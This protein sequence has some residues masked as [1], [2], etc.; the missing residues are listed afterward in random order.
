LQRSTHADAINSLT[1]AIDLLQKL[2]DSPERIQRELL[3]QLALGPALIAVKAWAAPEVERAYTRARELCERLGDPPEL[4]PVLWG[5]WVMHMV[6]G[7][8]RTAHELAEQLLRQAQSAH[9][10]ALL[11]LGHNAL[12]DTLFYMGELLLAREH[13]EL[14]ISLYD[15]ERHWPLTFR[16]G[17]VDPCVVCLSYACQTL[18]TL[19]Y[20][21][22][23]LK[24]GNE[25]VALAQALSH[26]HSLI[27]AENF[28]GNLRQFRREA[29]AAQEA[30]ERLIALSTE[31]GI[32]DFLAV[33]TMQRG[34]AMA[35]QG[36]TEGE[37]AQIQEGLAA[38]RATGAEVTLPYYLSWL[39][40]AYGE[41]GRLDNEL[42]ALTQALAAADE[43]EDRFWIAEIHRLKGELLLKQNHSNVAEAQSCFRRAVEIA[44]NQSAKSL[45][46]RATTS[47]ARLLAKQGRRDEA[48][49]MLGEIYGW[50][51]E[52]FDTADLKDA[53]AL[54]DELA[55]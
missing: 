45:V 49:T 53:K 13:L 34:W 18:W 48:R 42:G 54:L 21:D 27:F 23:A 46:L 9:D 16:Y 29:R 55:E 38:Q 32:N 39:A 7:E 8:L 26:P 6:R 5:L 4:F 40:E 17:G 33:A 19:G 31:R 41:T 1:A 37:I 25:A 30:A 15:R 28:L 50:F 11:L 2:P 14:A 43:N 47:L 20:P 24:R 10:Q 52:G 44:R 3:L 12:G 36:G 35:K 51:T 22:Q